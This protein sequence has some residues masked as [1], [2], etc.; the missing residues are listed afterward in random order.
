VEEINKAI[1][2]MEHVTQQNAALV[3]QVTAATLSFE[4]EAKR[5]TEAV[6]RFKF[7][8]VEGESS[9]MSAASG[10][11]LEAAKSLRRRIAQAA[12]LPVSEEPRRPIR[13]AA[14]R[15]R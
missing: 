5:L 8:D 13:G 6:S 9:V 7:A 2:Q 1:V 14:R 10:T 12:V 15:T 4:E 11:E 3:E